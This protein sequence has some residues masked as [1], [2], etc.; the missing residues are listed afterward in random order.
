M[1]AAFVLPVPLAVLAACANKT[2]T[3]A[4]AAPIAREETAANA[5]TASSSTT[6]PAAAAPS[7][8]TT[9]P[10]AAAVPSVLPFGM[11]APG[12]GVASVDPSGHALGSI[13]D[14]SAL[15]SL[16]GSLPPDAI[17]R[18]VVGSRSTFTACYEAG[19]L[20]NPALAGVVKTRF[21]I[22]VDGAV[23]SVEDAG[24]TLSNPD[25]LACVGRVFRSLTFPRPKGGTVVVVFPMTFSA[26]DSKK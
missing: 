5:N 24:S 19:L 10:Q 6:P 23:T 15:G 20:K 3:P 7:S 22:G 14:P 21:E 16:H 18:T 11:T 26:G 2:A 4:D 8:S 1:R 9:T 13:G 17:K 12:V 25:V